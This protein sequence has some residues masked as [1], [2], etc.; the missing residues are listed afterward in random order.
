MSA[1]RLV[2]GMYG[3][4]LH[5][6]NDRVLRTSIFPRDF[7]FCRNGIKETGERRSTWFEPS[8]QLPEPYR[9]LIPH[10]F[11]KGGRGND[12]KMPLAQV[13]GSTLGLPGLPSTLKTYTSAGRLFPSSN[14]FVSKC[15]GR[16]S[17]TSNRIT[18]GRTCFHDCQYEEDLTSTVVPSASTRS[19]AS[20]STRTF[21]G[22]TPNARPTRNSAST[23]RR[24]LLTR[25]E[26][27]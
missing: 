24:E 23:P 3:T 19:H 17:A 10:D 25:S 12:V 20:H 22:S 14:V 11:V 6:G 15:H 16:C 2:G 7:C 21:R 1:W 27:D 9:L 4:V 13:Q 8:D 5:F 26:L 18:D